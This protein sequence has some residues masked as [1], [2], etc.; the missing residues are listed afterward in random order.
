S[1]LLPETTTDFSRMTLVNRDMTERLTIDTNLHF[2]NFRSGICAEAGNLVI[3]ELKQD[4][5]TYSQMKEIL[6]RHR[7][8]PYRL[9]KYCVAVSLT[10]PSARPGRFREKIQHIEKIINI[11][12]IKR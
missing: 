6:L 11:K 5:K 7:I 12:L 2:R 10:D 1:E 9:S 3:I 8:F 4:G